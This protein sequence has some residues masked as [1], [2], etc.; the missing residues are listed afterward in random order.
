[1][2]AIKEHRSASLGVYHKVTL[3]INRVV[4][5]LCPRIVNG[6]IV[7][8]AIV[9]ESAKCQYTVFALFTGD[10]VPSGTEFIGM[11]DFSH[12]TGSRHIFVS[13]EKSQ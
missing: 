11:V 7:L 1:M 13:G 6:E 5:W 2:H 10:E 8:S 12:Y 4:K 9:D 3:D